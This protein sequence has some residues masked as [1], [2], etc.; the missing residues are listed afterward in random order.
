MVCLRFVSGT[1]AFVYSISPA[2]FA[3]FLRTLPP[4]IVRDKAVDSSSSITGLYTRLHAYLLHHKSYNVPLVLPSV[5][6]WHLSLFP[7]MPA[8]TCAVLR[9]P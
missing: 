1:S 2:T 5:L 3:D 4:Y 9:F 7:S 6:V 8:M